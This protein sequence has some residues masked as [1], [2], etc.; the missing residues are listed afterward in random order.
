M[1]LFLRIA[2]SSLC[3]LMFMAFSK[4]LSVWRGEIKENKDL[5]ANEAWS[6]NKIFLFRFKKMFSLNDGK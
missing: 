6:L 1:D 4:N 2:S 5:V 3:L